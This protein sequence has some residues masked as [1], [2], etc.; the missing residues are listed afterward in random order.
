[1]MLSMLLCYLQQMGRR[2]TDDMEIDVDD[3]QEESEETTLTAVY[4]VAMDAT[5]QHKAKILD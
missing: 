1:M 3:L 5:W 2:G 4:R